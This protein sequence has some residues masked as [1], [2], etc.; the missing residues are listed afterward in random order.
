MKV[1]CKIP[2]GIYLFGGSQAA[3]E[4][5]T[6]YGVAGLQV[7]VSFLG[8]EPMELG[9]LPAEQK[10]FKR[11]NW[12][13]LEIEDQ[14]GEETRLLDLIQ[15]AEYRQLV[16]ILADSANRVLSAVRNFGTVPHISELRPDPDKAEEL[17][18]MWGV[19]V[20]HDGQE[21]QR[22]IEERRSILDGFRA[23]FPQEEH[24][25]ELNVNTWSD[26]AEAIQDDIQPTPEQEFLTNAIEH[27]RL[28]NFRLAV[29]EAV[30]CLEVV[31]T[32]YLVQY[33]KSYKGLSNNRIKE[34][35]SPELS[36]TTRLSGLLDLT[37]ETHD[38]EKI[39]LSSVKTVVSWR[40]SITHRTGHLPTG[41]NEETI[42]A[43]V[44]DVFGLVDLLARRR[45]AIAAEPALRDVGERIAEEFGIL[46]PQLWAAPG[47]R[48]LV[49]F[50][51]ILDRELPNTETLERISRRVGELFA[52]RDQKFRQEEHLYILFKTVQ[53][54]A[55]AR[56]RQGQLV[57]PQEGN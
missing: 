14:P 13:Q 47:H 39:N 54:G 51:F 5:W 2:F 24:I 6:S 10:F 55:R 38:L 34:F 43:H 1:R 19:E 57:L 42:R 36:L 33:L 16:G 4:I 20:S 17:L 37:L 27:L 50:T 21:W 53:G 46:R 29:V 26:I 40:N 41:L 32:Q 48:V 3:L 56:W 22:L 49:Q 30:I 15:P 25:R 45:D 28:K 23:L 35:L 52:S 18:K 31:L 12:L 44:S 7:S 11:C 9:V 8:M